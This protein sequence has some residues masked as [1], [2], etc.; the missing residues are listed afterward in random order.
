MKPEVIEE[1]EGTV[2]KED[3]Q[4]KWINFFEVILTTMFTAALAG[5]KSQKSFS[6]FFKDLVPYSRKERTHKQQLLYLGFP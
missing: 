4:Q 6:L 2:Q 3:Q 1:T 5:L